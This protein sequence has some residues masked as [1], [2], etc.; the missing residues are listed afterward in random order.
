MRNYI[1]VSEFT[2]R[3][4]IY[5]ITLKMPFPSISLLELAYTIMALRLFRYI[6][7]FAVR[8]YCL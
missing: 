1:I 7:G 8:E 6:D 3:L 5:E 4:T 2:D